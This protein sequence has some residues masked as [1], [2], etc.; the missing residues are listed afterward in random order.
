MIIQIYAFTD[1]DTAYQ[2]ARLGVDHIGFV[3]GEY[4]QVY[5]ELSFS[6]AH[7]IVSIL[8]SG[9]LSVALTM[10]ADINEILRMAEAV[11]PHIIHISS[12]VDMVN[13]QKMTQLRSRLPADIQLMKAIPVVDENSFDTADEFAQV[14]D[15]LLLDS[16]HAGF[17]GVGATGLTH[18]WEISRK[19]VKAVA[20]PVILAGGLSDLN[21][22]QAIQSV[23]PTGVDSNTSTN[24]NGSRVEKDLSK[25]A[26]FVNAVRSWERF[27]EQN[28]EATA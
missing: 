12:D 23:Q 28:G 18:D 14:S 17:P 15:F 10:S 24:F 22:V 7:E 5:G 9:A 4:G 13:M 1:P 2:A 11:Q 16:K 25:I 3:A 20:V 6:S 27:A 19:I 26:A 21:V 8:P